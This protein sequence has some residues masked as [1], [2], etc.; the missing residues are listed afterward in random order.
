[1]ERLSDYDYALPQAAIAQTPLSD[2][3]ASRLLWLRRDGTIEHRAFREVTEI[4]NPGDLLIVNDTR[5]S[6]LRLFGHKRT[7]AAVELLLLRDLGGGAFET[8]AKPGNRLQPGAEVV[9]ERGL[10]CRF[11]ESLGEGRKRVQFYSESPIGEVLAGQGL[12]PL[13]PYIHERLLDQERYQTV[14]N[15][16]PGSSAAPTAGLHFTSQILSSL[17]S[18]G[19]RVAR[20][21]LDVGLD[22]FRPVKTD[23]LDDHAM[24]GERC[25]VPEETVEAVAKCEGRVIA[26]GTTAVRTLESFAVGPRSLIQGEKVTSIFIRPGYKFNIIDGMFTNFHMPRTTMLIMLSALVDRE[27]LLAAYREALTQGYRFL[28]FGDSMLIL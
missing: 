11:E 18:R 2:R 22:T 24:H 16:A 3:S 15:K 20:V 14:Y 28:S 1:L 27:A 4:L 12:T 10:W 26:V 19:V 8:L 5:V 7:G 13:P 6:A 21:T 25:S 9:F 23:N 17:E